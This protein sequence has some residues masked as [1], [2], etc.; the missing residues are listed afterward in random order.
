MA[1]PITWNGI[2]EYFGPGEFGDGAEQGMD[3]EFLL[4]LYDFRKAMDN[5][6]LIHN[7]GGFSRGGHSRKSYHYTGRA[8]DFYFKHNRNIS[9]RRLI[10]TALQA[11]L[12]GI[13]LYPYWRPFPGGFHLD[14][15]ETGAFNIWWRDEFGK[16]HYV[17]PHDIP[18]SLEE[19]R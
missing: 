7:N 6:I 10:V 1:R 19:W 3:D 13:G 14:N 2:K 5:P 15:R 11:G 17:F 8:V 9:T 18:E 16:Y 12:C 4:C